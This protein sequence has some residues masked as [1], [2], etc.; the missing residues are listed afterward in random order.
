MSDEGAEGVGKVGR[1]VSEWPCNCIICRAFIHPLM[2]RSQRRSQEAITEEE[3]ERPVESR[4]EVGQVVQEGAQQVLDLKKI[5]EIVVSS[6]TSTVELKL[7]EFSSRINTVEEEVRNLREEFSRNLDEVRSALVDIR[8]TITDTLNPFNVLRNYAESREDRAP[9]LKDVERI[10]EAIERR[11]GKRAEGLG[12]GVEAR[13]RTGEEVSK[14]HVVEVRPSIRRIGLGGFIKLIK[15]ADDMLT[16]FPKEVIDNVIR[17][18][19]DAGIISA[20]EGS[21]ALDIVEFVYTARKM[22]IKVTEQIVSLYTFAKIFGIEDKEADKELVNIA[23][24]V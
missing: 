24:N 15:W 23:T 2:R 18:S 20:D 19:S 4:S 9:S 5:E 3:F 17:F 21:I 8:A 13:E 7:R 14:K 1:S 11:A 6:V 22:G 10:F 12:E 16:R